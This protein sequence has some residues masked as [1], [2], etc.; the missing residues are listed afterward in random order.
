[1]SAPA[2]MRIAYLMEGWNIFLLS[3]LCVSI[4]LYD[5]R[6]D[7]VGIFPC[8]MGETSTQTSK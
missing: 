7:W 4:S 1:M 2:K 5:Y 8:F 6:L 3:R